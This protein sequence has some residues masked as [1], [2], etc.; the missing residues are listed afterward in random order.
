MRDEGE[1]GGEMRNRERVGERGRKG[2]KEK[3]MRDESESERERERREGGREG[4]RVK[5]RKNEN[6]GGR[7]EKR[8]GGGETMNHI[9]TM[10]MGEDPY[11]P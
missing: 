1:E 5:G 2:G 9:R 3:S 6:V 11:V 10:D 8:R 4:G 7:E